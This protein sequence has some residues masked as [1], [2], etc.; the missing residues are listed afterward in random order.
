[1]VVAPPPKPVEDPTPAALARL[2]TME[3]EQ[4][5]AAEDADRRAEALDVARRS[6]EAESKRW[7]RREALVRAQV[8]GLAEK[9]EKLELEADSLALERDILA[10]ERDAAKAALEKARARNGGYAI[11]PHRGPNGT[12]QRPITIECRDGQAILQ[13]AGLTFSMLDMSP[14]L[15]PRSS[16]VARAVV[17]ELVRT[18][19]TL[20]PDGSAVV[21]YIYFIIRPDGVRPYYQARTLLEPL[22]IAFGYEL[23]EQSWEID[24]PDFDDLASWDGTAPRTKDTGASSL[25][26]LAGATAGN[27]GRGGRV[28]VDRPAANGS[29]AV[30]PS[31]RNGSP[32]LYGFV[33]PTDRPGSGGRGAGG[34][35]SRRDRSPSR[36]RRPAPIRRPPRRVLASGWRVANG[37]G[38]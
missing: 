11:M 21:P 29:P 13:P 20:A 34:V 1:M 36:Q 19:R 4:R 32:E 2:S 8:D 33:W 3:D 5:R 16:P 6:A 10:Q 22:G 25:A 38:R 26:G 30:G 15:N 31:G 7:R 17:A 12:W 28:A 27:G 14:L 9:A 24:F 37:M 18:R 23:V 35:D